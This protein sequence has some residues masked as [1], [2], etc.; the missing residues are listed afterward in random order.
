M[1]KDAFGSLKQVVDDLRYVFTFPEITPACLQHLIAN[2]DRLITGKY[3]TLDGRRKCVMAML[4]EILPEQDQILS[5]PD[6]TRFF[7]RQ[8]G[9]YGQP[10][11]VAARDSESYQPAKWLVRLIDRQ[12]CPKVIQ[13]YGRNS[14]A[15]SQEELHDLIVAVATTVLDERQEI[16]KLA[17]RA[18]KR[19]LA[20][21]KP[22]HEDAPVV[23]AV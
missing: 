16:E 12:F 15:L 14:M 1:K 10:G 20:R 5:K 19:V 18:E 8:V 3:S 2:R 17:A 6:L 21:I 4:T 7:G 23:Q 22:D 11:F 9:Q 13:R